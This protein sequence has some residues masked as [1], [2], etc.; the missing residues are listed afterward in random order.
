[1][2]TYLTLLW[3]FSTLFLGVHLKIL[4]KFRDKEEYEINDSML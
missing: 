1:M 4:T 3:K 2:C